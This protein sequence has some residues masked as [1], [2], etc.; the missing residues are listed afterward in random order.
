MRA[1]QLRSLEI[2]SE[3][4]IGDY[5]ADTLDFSAAEHSAFRLLLLHTWLHGAPGRWRMRA[6]A[7]VDRTQWRCTKVLIQPL[8]AVATANIDKW[9]DAI[10]AF[11]GQRLPA[12][13]WHVLRSITLERDNYICQYC[14][15]AARPHVDHKIP[16]S[17]GGTNLF[18]NL[19]T[20]CGPCNQSKGAKLPTEWTRGPQLLTRSSTGPA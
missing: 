1:E 2:Y 14:G 10:R 20:A 19:I 6:L 3:L 5:F 13:E 17:R 16:L 18:E 9:K 7:Q 15:S 11:D 4:Y 12:A 8:L